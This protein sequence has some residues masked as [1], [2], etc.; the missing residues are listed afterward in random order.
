MGKSGGKISFNVAL[1]TL[2]I[3]NIGEYVNA[4][5]IW[6]VESKFSISFLINSCITL[7]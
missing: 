3:E 2:F 4:K 1:H 7:L 6:S 5:E